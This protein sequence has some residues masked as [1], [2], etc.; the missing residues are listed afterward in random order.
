MIIQ[1]NIPALNTFRQMKANNFGSAKALEKLSSGLRINRA[2][3][4]A[5]GLAISEKMRAQIRG[6]N[7]AS[8]NAQDGIS[9][10]QSADGAM[11]EVH[12]VLHRMREL[13]VQAADDTNEFIDRQAIQDEINQLVSE[14]E[15]ISQTTEFNKKLI[16]DGSLNNGKY[17]KLISGSN[18][19]NLSLLGQVDEAPLINGLTSVAV[20]QAGEK[21]N[22]S[23]DFK[24]GG[25]APAVIGGVVQ[26][27]FATTL[28][29]QL[30]EDILKAAAPGAAASDG[31]LAVAVEIGD[32]ED[33]I[34]GKV[35]DMLSHALGHDWTVTASGGRVKVEANY[36]GRFDPEAFTI[37]A[38]DPSDIFDPSEWSTDELGGNVQGNAGRD[39]VIIV[40]GEVPPFEE[41]N[42]LTEWDSAPDPDGALRWKDAYMQLYLGD[43]TGERQSE[44]FSF[45]ITDPTKSSNAIIATKD[46]SDLTL[47]IGANTG[48]NQT[49]QLGIRALSSVSLGVS[50][51]NVLNHQRAQMALSNID[52]GI[53]GV[54]N[55]RANLGAIQNRLEHTMANLDTVAE[56]LQD[57]E[58]RL[59]DVDMAKEMMNFTRY[60]ILMQSSQAMAAQANS[61][62]Q[63]ILQ[64]LR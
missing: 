6:L 17:V 20:A 21:F 40:N 57:A 46:G 56:N 3:D 49:V 43:S 4:D 28:S 1:N 39:A 30:S 50:E 5:A 44:Q 38:A 35:R 11:M 55:Q 36:I 29:I 54:S 63:G 61:L 31:L 62:P 7:R 41:F 2:G 12:A 8:S 19:S 26:E 47:Q 33:V 32:T 9:L 27:G 14:V 64:L 45:K 60:N 53:Q 58:S 15:R 48:Y 52:G 16:L 10:V 22:M 23:F 34:A 13:A 51:L 59:R 37:E 42:S 18:I 25:E 24:M